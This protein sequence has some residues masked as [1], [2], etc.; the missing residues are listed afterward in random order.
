VSDRGWPYWLTSHILQLNTPWPESGLCA[1]VM[2]SPPAITTIAGAAFR[3]LCQETHRGPSTRNS[4]ASRGKPRRGPVQRS[5]ACRSCWQPGRPVLTAGR[6]SGGMVHA[7]PVAGILWLLG[8]GLAF[9]GRRFNLPLTKPAR[10]R[11]HGRN[12]QAAGKRLTR[13]SARAILQNEQAELDDGPLQSGSFAHGLRTAHLRGSPLAQP[14]L[15]P[16]RT[17]ESREALTLLHRET[18]KP[19]G[20][21]FVHTRGKPRPGDFLARTAALPI[22]QF[23]E[24]EPTPRS[25]LLRRIPGPIGQP[26][27]RDSPITTRG[28]AGARPPRG[29]ADR[30]QLTLAGIATP[31]WGST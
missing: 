24:R 20:G 23:D 15:R 9:F 27:H 12:N 11:L 26:R 31:R 13:S 5:S 21:R 10:S 7:S 30:A 14:N 25:A 6:P 4:R 28:P 17:R 16:L 29:R 19:A 18:G 3:V 22:T 1:R 8:W 2:C